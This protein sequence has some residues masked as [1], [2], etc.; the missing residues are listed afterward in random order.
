MKTVLIIAVA[1]AL[2][3]AA[4]GAWE[5]EGEWGKL[6]TGNGQF[7]HPTGIAVA[8]NGNVYVA[9]R[10]NHRVQ[11]FTAT[12]SFL[13]KWG[14]AGAGQGQ[15]NRPIGLKI[16][17]NRNVYVCEFIG[18]RIQYFTPAGTFIGSW[19]GFNRPFDLEIA[20][21]GTVYV[22]DMHH[23]LCQYFTTA[24][25]RLGSW[26]LPTPGYTYGIGRADNGNLYFTNFGHNYVYYCNPTT[27]SLLSSWGSFGTGN[28]QFDKPVRAEVGPDGCVYISDG[29]GRNDRVQ[30]F[31]PTG[32]Y[33]GKWGSTGSG[34][35][36]FNTPGDIFFVSS[37]ARCY[38]GDFENH[39]VQYFK[40]T[41]H[42]VA[43]ASLGKVKALFR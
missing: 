13:G 38:V 17:P 29:A 12:G 27:G 16:A 14:S 43:P 34:N 7:N 42:A 37:G 33:L 9:D 11:Y 2:A 5:Y 20:P 40:D 15:F 26:P 41:E 19:G 35:G 8:A 32:S 3:A 21:S 6:G 39:R 31:T 23:D 25:S 10:D 30:Y 1:A 22:V 28:G 36:E 18:D 4:Y 24:G